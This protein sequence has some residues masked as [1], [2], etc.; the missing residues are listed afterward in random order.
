L[1]AGIAVQAS[2]ATRSPIANP[3]KAKKTG[4]DNR[5]TQ[6]EIREELGLSKEGFRRLTNK[7]TAKLEEKGLFGNL[8][9][10]LTTDLGCQSDHAWLK[11]VLRGVR[12]ECISD[13]D[14]ELSLERIDKCLWERVI[15]LNTRENKP[16]HKKR[17]AEPEKEPEEEPEKPKRAKKVKQTPSLHSQMWMLT[18]EDA[19]L[20]RELNDNADRQAKELEKGEHDQDWMKS[21]QARAARI[22]ESR[23]KAKIRMDRVMEMMCMEEQ[24]EW[25]KHLDN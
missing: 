25:F 24:E 19:R 11:I 9:F 23:K 6:G 14:D 4:G 17:N 13:M 1:E 16:W 20:Q 5:R 21:L 10:R 22:A 12:D 7:I 18:N 8:D 15:Y 2:K 3:E